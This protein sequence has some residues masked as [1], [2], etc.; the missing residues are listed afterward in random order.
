MHNRRIDINSRV[1]HP[2]SLHLWKVQE[3]GRGIPQTKWPC[4]ACKGR[5]CEKCDHTGLQYKSS[6]QGLIGDPLLG[7]FGSEEHVHGM[8]REDI[9]VRCLGRGRPFVIE[10]KK[11]IKR[12][13]DSNMI[14][15]AINSSAEGRIE[16]SDIRP[17]NR[18]EVVRVKDTPAEVLQW[19]KIEPITESELDELTQ[20]MEIPKNNQDEKS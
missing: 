4:R 8:G 7:I 12:D 15:E 20:V 9:D 18:S 13:I 3:I 14:L 17:S 6:V 19:Y 5:G 2:I 16:V 10:M 11:P 1:R